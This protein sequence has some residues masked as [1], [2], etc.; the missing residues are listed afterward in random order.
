MWQPNTTYVMTINGTFTIPLFDTD[1]V[2]P[3]VFE[4][5]EVDSNGVATRTFRQPW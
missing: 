1:D 5:I 4:V 3:Q 2:P